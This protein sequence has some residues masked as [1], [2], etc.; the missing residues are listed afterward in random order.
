MTFTNLLVAVGH[1]ENPHDFVK[2]VILSLEP[3]KLEENEP[4]KKKSGVQPEHGGDRGEGGAT[5]SSQ[6]APCGPRLPGTLREARR[7]KICSYL[8]IV[9]IAPPPP[10]FLYFFWPEKVTEKMFIMSKFTQKR[11]SKVFELEST[12]YRTESWIL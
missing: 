3:R 1:L 8:D 5:G 11:D 12:P 9:K 10:V 2:L 7:H 4:Y 6:P